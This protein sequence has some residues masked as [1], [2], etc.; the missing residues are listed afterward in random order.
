[1]NGKAMAETGSE[2]SFAKDFID[3]FSYNN[4]ATLAT[5]GYYVITACNGS[6][7]SV[8]ST[9]GTSSYWGVFTVALTRG[10]GWNETASTTCSLYADSNG[11]KA[12]TLQEVYS[13]TYSYA[14]S[15]TSH[16][17]YAQVYP[18]NSSYVLFRK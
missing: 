13:Y 10:C 16:K 4:R 15:L 5:S 18:T 11:D 7:T 17:Q 3:A 2:E 8:E 6:Q 1:M 14:L 9:L 12:L